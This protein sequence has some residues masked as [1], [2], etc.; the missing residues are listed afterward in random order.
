MADNLADR[1]KS[2]AREHARGKQAEIDQQ[3]FQE[4]VHTFISDNARSE[5]DNLIRLLKACAEQMN[6]SL[7]DLPRFVPSAYFLQQGN[8]ALYFHFDK[9]IINR[10]DNALVF[11][12]GPMPNTMYFLGA[13]PSPVRYRLQA[14]ASDDL[15]SIVWVGDLGELTSAQLVDVV[16]EQLTVYYLQHKS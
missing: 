16:L 4:R 12:V 1:L 2:L 7:G 11:S 3:K 10:P 5:Y 14:A 15:T 13:P 9:P 8:M 6:S